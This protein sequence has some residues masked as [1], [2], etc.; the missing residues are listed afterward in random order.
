MSSF[1]I[2]GDVCHSHHAVPLHD[3]PAYSWVSTQGRSRWHHLLSKPKT[4]QTRCYAGEI[5]KGLKV[6][7]KWGSGW[8]VSP[9]MYN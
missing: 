3:N 6:I 8:A 2:P 9:P 5:L 7:S 1:L 4:G